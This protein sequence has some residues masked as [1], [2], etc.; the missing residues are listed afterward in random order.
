MFVGVLI[1]AVV[2]HS[3]AGLVVTNCIALKRLALPT[4]YSIEVGPFIAEADAIGTDSVL[5]EAF[6]K[7]FKTCH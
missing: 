5:S 7:E 2:L 3:Y 6:E 4:V 1:R